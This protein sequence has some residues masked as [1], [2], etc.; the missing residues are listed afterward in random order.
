M[1]K[2]VS[3]RCDKSLYDFLQSFAQMH[4]QKVGEVI[5]DALKYFYMRLMVGDF[6]DKNYE[7]VRKKFLSKLE[8]IP[9]TYKSEYWTKILNSRAKMRHK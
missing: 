3:F 5:R 6:K 1:R 8:N 9:N 4:D 2:K 7:E